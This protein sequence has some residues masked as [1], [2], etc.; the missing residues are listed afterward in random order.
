MSLKPTA[1]QIGTVSEH[2]LSARY[3]LAGA[4]QVLISGQGVTA[5]ILP[6]EKEKPEDKL[7]KDVMASKVRIRFHVDKDAVPGV[8]DF[9]VFTPRGASTLG[10]LV[11]TRDTVVPESNENNT[12]EQSQLVTIPSTLCGTIE[13]AE[14]VDWYKFSITTRTQLVFHLQAQRL[15][16]RLHDMQTRI[17]PM[18]TLRDAG[19]AT[20]ASSDNVLAGDPLLHF[21]FQKPGDYLL[22]VRDVRYQGNADW[23]YAIEVH[24]RPWIQ[25]VYPPAVVASRSV[26]LTPLGLNLPDR[27]ILHVNVP[28]AESPIAL[29]SSQVD[30]VPTNEFSV[31]VLPSE[32][33]PI[34]AESNEANATTRVASVSST[35]NTEPAPNVPDGRSVTSF[36]FPA[37]LVGGLDVPNEVDRFEFEAKAKDKFSFDVIARRLRSNIDAKIRI[38]NDK[39]ATV[40]EVDDA[41]YQRVNQSDPWLENWTAPA[42]GKYVLEV[43]DLHQRGGTGFVYAVKATRA[44]PYFLLEADTD[45]TLLA[46]GMGSVVYV[47]GL[48]KNGFA[49]DIQLDVMG[50]PPGV[51]ATCGR[52]ASDLNDGIIYLEAATDA[53][54]GAANIQIVGRATHSVADGSQTSLSSS[55]TIL[56]EYY[57]PGGGR[58]HYPVEMHTVSV[59]EPMDIR[60]IQLSAHALSMKPGESQRIDIH[61]ERAPDFQGNVTLDLL[62][63]HL[64]QPHG[65]SLPK[66]VTVDVANSKTLLTGSESQGHI[67]LKASPDAPAI[68][69][70]L[71]PVNVHISI[72]FVMKHTFCPKPLSVSIVR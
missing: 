9:R 15:L 70:Q 14:D 19:G 12:K 57:S 63:Q 13:K 43:Q 53:P 8:R 30:G 21:D 61:V 62:Y 31:Y 16:N 17:D 56:Q 67:T 40:V 65:N 34:V 11:L 69:E 25:Q 36:A 24:D 27:P 38:A 50:L 46:P 3:N 58:G 35:P 71:V 66:G 6:N 26:Q 2:E 18:L 59:A 47:R 52:I 49:G 29:V 72:N 42:D 7:K 44:E 10:Q 39:G 48:R 20:L 64:E 5:E 33:I 51:S 32:D 41:P 37:V 23:V 60:N 45:K 22:E 1:A 54:P 68:S 55:A 28:T 4:T